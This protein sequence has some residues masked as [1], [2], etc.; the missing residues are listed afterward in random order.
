MLLLT[1]LWGLAP[2]IKD[3]IKLGRIGM[4]VELG[5]KRFEQ[6]AKEIDV[7]G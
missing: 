6:L 2:P 1:S 3:A 5:K 4:G 7:L